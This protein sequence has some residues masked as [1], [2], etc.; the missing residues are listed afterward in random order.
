MGAMNATAWVLTIGA[1]GSGDDLWDFAVE[2]CERRGRG[3]TP[4]LHALNGERVLGEQRRYCFHPTSDAAVEFRGDDF[5][6][7]V[8]AGVWWLAAQMPTHDLWRRD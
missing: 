2:L 1:S 6:E 4:G 7:V 5:R 3:E 8:L